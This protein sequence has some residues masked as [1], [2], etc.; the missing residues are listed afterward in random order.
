MISSLAIG[1][2]L[3]NSLTRGMPEPHNDAIH[4][5]GATCLRATR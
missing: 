4:F 3:P 2:I 5:S 1:L